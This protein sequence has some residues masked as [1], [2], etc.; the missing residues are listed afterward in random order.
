ME[1]D[2]FYFKEK[3]SV[4][5]YVKEHLCLNAPVLLGLK[6]AAIFTVSK[7]EKARLE[8]LL[9]SSGKKRG[10]NCPLEEY[11]GGA[12]M[13]EEAF[14]DC[15][16]FAIVTLH[17]GEKESILLYRKDILYAHLADRKVKR[18]LHSLAL[19]YEEGTDWILHFKK[20]FLE[21][22]E[23]GREFPHEIGIFLGYPLWDIRA[24]MQNPRREA[25]LTGYWK[26][27]Y[28]VEKAREQFQKYDR[29][30][31]LLQKRMEE[32]EKGTERKHIASLCENVA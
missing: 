32:R 20:R 29:C 27:Y 8:E 22:K 13:E 6:P 24:F 26:V 15:R 2:K 5:D 9:S 12:R 19:G 14:P 1:R 31:A 10:G 7:A 30:I 16:V 23:E 25:K 4:E 3:N 18:F 21:Y 11:C 17:S 28:K